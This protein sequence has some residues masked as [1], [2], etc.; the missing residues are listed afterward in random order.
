M[1]DLN[2]RPETIEYLEENIGSMLFDIGLCNIVLGIFSGKRN[3]N[4]QVKDIKL[5][6][7]CT[8]KEAINK[9]KR[10]PIECEN[11]FANNISQKGLIFKL[12]KNSY[13]STSKT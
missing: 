8:I 9:M 3:K 5:K 10:Q 7:I 2:V 13:K 1:K 4:K 11:I 12:Y 6:S